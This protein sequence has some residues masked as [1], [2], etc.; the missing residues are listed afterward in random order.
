M[1]D[2]F[3]EFDRDTIDKA[4]KEVAKE[5]RKQVGK[6]MPAEV[7]LV[8]GASVLI[9][10]GFRNMTTDIDGVIHAAS[11]MQDAIRII[12]DKNHFPSGW[13]NSDFIR[14]ESYSD[15]LEEFSEYYR[16]YANVLEVRTISAEY[17]IAMKLR[18]DRSYKNDIS[19]IL[20][21]LNEQEKK[22][23]PI[24]LAEIED[25][26][27]N[28]YGSWKSLSTQARNTIQDIIETGNYE[29]QYQKIVDNEKESKAELLD[30][31]EKY[32]G[33]LKESNINQILN[34]LESKERQ[35]PPSE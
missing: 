19:D 16:T 21:I 4:L 3:T 5:Y 18:S 31:E 33:V 7:I 6:T 13:L 22:G 9:N 15:K 20:G 12:G 1:F 24:S 35:K 28:L 23:E 14:T 10:Y 11:A 17:L 29:E 8:G 27:N 30:F 2:H 32:P 34:K 25:A 26:V